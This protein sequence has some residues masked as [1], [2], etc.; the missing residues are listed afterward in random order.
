MKKYLF[1]FLILCLLFSCSKTE[2]KIPEGVLSKNEM[3]L[4]LTDVNIAQ[5]AVANYSS[6]DT[7]KFSMADY[8]PEI[9][10]IHHITPLQYDSSIT[11]YS[12]HPELMSEIYDNVIT[13]LSKKQSEVSAH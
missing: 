2:V 10:S 4:L 7:V 6:G 9:L 5:A 13:E 12:R 8:L 1:H 11:F 3:A